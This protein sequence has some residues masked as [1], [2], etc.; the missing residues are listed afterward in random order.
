M[1]VFTLGLAFSAG[2]LVSFAV[3]G[4]M[5]VGLGQ[6]WGGLFQRPQVT[7]GLAAV[8]TAFAMSLFGVFAI[9]P[10][11]VVNELG[12][13]VQQ[14]G[15]LSAFGMGLLATLLGTAC[16]APFLSV[17]IAFAVQQSPVAGVMVFMVAGLGMAI[18]YVILAAKPAWLK[19]IPKAGP[20]MK[21]FEHVMGFCLLGTT[22]FLLNP[23]AA[24]L[25]GLGLVVTLAFLL[26]VAVGAWLYGHVRFGDPSARRLKYYAAVLILIVGGWWTCFHFWQPIP[27]L[28]AAQDRLRL[29]TMA[30]DASSLDWSRGDI[31]WVPYTSQKALSE[32]SLGRTI[33]I[34]YTAEW[35]VNCKA[36]EKLVLNTAAVKKA[37]REA[38]VVPFKADYTSFNPEIKADLDRFK[39]SGVPMY[40]I[41]PAN[42]PDAPIVLDEVLTPSAVIDGLRRAGAGAK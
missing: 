40:V 26:C 4:V 9:Y 24:Q 16:T 29:G 22:V 42:R 34:D 36:N 32:V 35:C 38:G 28:L 1:R 3:L 7:I 10:P 21:T 18:P 31:P 39:R 13:K 2:I 12:E 23:L 5:I 41:I 17:A 33:L 30:H 19:V 6:Q 25:G 14:E 27:E 8:V 20:W 37:M 11:R 15:H